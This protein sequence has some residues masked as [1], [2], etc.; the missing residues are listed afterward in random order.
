MLVVASFIL[1]MNL[2]RLLVVNVV[3]ANGLMARYQE[4]V[5]AIV[6]QAADG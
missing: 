5:D 4:A 2:T 3:M 1:F 6:A